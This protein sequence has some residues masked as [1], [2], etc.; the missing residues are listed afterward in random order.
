VRNRPLSSGS[1]QRRLRALLVLVALPALAV[2]AVAAPAR[3]TGGTRYVA[4]GN[5]QCTDSGSGTSAQPY[6]TIQA[7]VSAAAPG[8]TV[9][10][11]SGTYAENVSVKHSGTSTAPITISVA[12]GASVKVTGGVHGFAV[13][14]SST[15]PVSWI[16]IQG[17]TVTQTSDVGIYLSYASHITVTGNSVSYAGQPVSGQTHAGIAL[18]NAS[19]S[20]VAGNT[21]YH[22]SDAGISVVNGSIDNDI[23]GN[24]TFANARQYTRAAPGIDIRAADNTVEQN[25]SHDNEDSG[26]QLYNGASDAVVD[27]N[28]SYGNG[29]H[30]IDTLNSPGATIVA[31]SVYSNHTA[32]I[33]VEGTS[34]G[35]TVRN[36]ISVDNGLTSTTTKG[37]IRVDPTAVSGSTIDDDLVWLHQ[38]SGPSVIMTWGSTTYTSFATFRSASGQEAHGIL[39]N[40]MWVAPVSGS[41][42]LRPG[43][44]AIDSADSGAPDQ[45]ATDAAGNPRVDD[46]ATP[47]TGLGP[48]AYDDRGALEYQ[49][50]TTYDLPP[51]VAVT[52]STATGQAPLATTVDASGSTDNDATPIASYTFD[53]G[54]GVVVGPQ[55]SPVASHIYSTAGAFTVAVTVTDTAGLAD[56]GYAQV[57]VAPSSTTNLVPNP[58]FESGTSGWNTSGRSGITLTQVAGGHS[59]SYAAALTNTGSTTAP[60]CTLNDSPNV[61]GQ[62]Y[63]GSYAYTAS[64]WVMAPTAGARLTAR[65]REFDASGASAGSASVSIALTTSWQQVSVVYRP[66]DPGT[67]N[68]DF[69][70]YLTNAAPGTCFYADDVAITL[71]P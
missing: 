10:V 65:I 57:S 37:D 28:I 4:T 46:P 48:R 1:S 22:N 49:P 14:G 19:D 43:S 54:D 26:I 71:G 24:T 17:F 66:A 8:D 20:S 29:D 23:R 16:V 68:L 44:P 5:P 9:V 2:L 62:T 30:G 58:G 12:P 36:N 7:A 53:F 61:V 40:P 45:P 39:A 3:A 51:T 11:A 13:S 34:Q 47:N 15:A 67:S 69:N 41:F 25:V 21:S 18:S 56:R 55:S 33:N 31:N 27:D 6:C 50:G 42:A 52:V 59:G 64:L 70:A 63:A 38:T 60:D 35:A 32:G